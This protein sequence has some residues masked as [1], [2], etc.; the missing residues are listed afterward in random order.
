MHL[1]SRHTPELYDQGIRTVWLT[2]SWQLFGP[3]LWYCRFSKQGSNLGPLQFFAAE[4]K[5]RF[6]AY[7]LALDKAQKAIVPTH[8]F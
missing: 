7:R 3:P 5:N 1:C 6:T 2:R 8:Y 4:H